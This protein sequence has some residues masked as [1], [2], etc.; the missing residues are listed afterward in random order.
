MWCI[1]VPIAANNGCAAVG[2]AP[3]LTGGAC[4][5]GVL[6]PQALA[7]LSDFDAVLCA[8]DDAVLRAMRVALAGRAGKLIP[9]FAEADM[10]RRCRIERHI[11]VDTTAAGGNASLLA[12]VG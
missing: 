10:A 1:W 6:N 8:G 2:V 9:L 5:D 7:G 11:C 3:G 4:V 12:E